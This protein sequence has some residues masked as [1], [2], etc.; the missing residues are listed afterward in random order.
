[1]RKKRI[2]SRKAAKAQ[3]KTEEGKR[4]RISSSFL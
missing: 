3:R 1:L 2:A 4:K